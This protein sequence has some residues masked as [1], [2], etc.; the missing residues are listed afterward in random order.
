MK[1][2]HCHCGLHDQ[3][4]KFRARKLGLL[5]ATLMV[6]HLL[7]HVVECLVLPAL[8]VGFSGH[9]DHNSAL[10]EGAEDTTSVASCLVNAEDLFLSGESTT[11][12][13]QIDFQKY[14]VLG[15]PADFAIPLPIFRKS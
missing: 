3:L 7:F 13:L 4:K 11:G 10:A 14:G 8:I 2:H 12:S 9:H 5:G 1:H 6:A 15:L